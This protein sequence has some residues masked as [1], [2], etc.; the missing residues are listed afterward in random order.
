[1]PSAPANSAPAV[2]RVTAHAA[3]SAR[4][5]STNPDYAK[6]TVA[7]RGVI[8][9][10]FPEVARSPRDPLGNFTEVAAILQRGS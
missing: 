3:S 5:R 2:G 7:R 6:I 4:R 9:G 8:T 10:N 1:M